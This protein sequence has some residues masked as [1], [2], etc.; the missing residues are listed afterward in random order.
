MP[1]MARLLMLVLLL[2]LDG[3]DDLPRDPEHTLER[4]RGDVLR[5]GVADNSPWV[6][7][8]RGQVKGVEARLINMLADE[9]DAEVVWVR[10]SVPELVSALAEYQ[11]DVVIGG[12]T[13]DSLFKNKVALT[14]SYHTEPLLLALPP[15]APTLAEIGGQEVVV[16]P[17]SEAAAQVHKHGGV[18]VPQAD[19]ANAELPV[20][21]PDWQRRRL[22]F[23]PTGVV[24]TRERHVMAL[25][26]GENAWLVYV[27][28]FLKRARPRADDLLHAVVAEDLRP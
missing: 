10:G 23:R 27:E 3:C 28:R 8:D 6:V 18:P 17:G 15:H 12:L 11:L 21:V 9:L 13:Q 24:L 25:P 5:V 4:V 16:A 2:G 1:A 14:L 22:G 19:L 7:L 26:P 20:A